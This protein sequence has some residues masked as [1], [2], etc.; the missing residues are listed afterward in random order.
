M[1]RVERVVGAVVGS[2]VGD[3]LGAPFEFGEEG[4]FS[5]RFPVAG[6]GGEMCGGGG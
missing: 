5:A 4:A 1:E 2:A 3:A 6:S